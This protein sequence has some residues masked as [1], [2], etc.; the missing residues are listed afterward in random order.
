MKANLKKMLG[1]ATLGMTLLTTTVPTWAGRVSTDS[2]II[3]NNQVS[4]WASGNLVD[5]RYSA[6]NKQLIQC[7]AFADPNNRISNSVVCGAADSTGNN[8]ACG[9]KDPRL[10]EVVQA[11]TDSSYIYFV[12]D[13]NGNCTHIVNYHGSDMLK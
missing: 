1:L 6:D 3:G 5:A 13:L 4:R 2:V 8:L 7:K 9:S 10:Q 11:M 12:A